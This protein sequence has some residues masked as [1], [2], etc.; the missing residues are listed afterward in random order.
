MC[1]PRKSERW[2]KYPSRIR[3]V[4]TQVASD[5]RN[6]NS[7]WLL[8]CKRTHMT[9]T[10]SI[11]SPLPAWP[12]S[13]SVSLGTHSSPSFSTHLA[14][15][16]VNAPHYTSPRLIIPPCIS[17]YF[18][19]PHHPLSSQHLSSPCLY[20]PCVASPQLT[21]PHRH[22][23]DGRLAYVTRINLTCTNTKERG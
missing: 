19:S 21:F 20:S 14:S 3:M 12:L 8:V 5:M 17:L 22:G 10:D 16:H 2:H 7:E 13:H 11:A 1:W 6:I 23:N 18:I 9:V 15:S 4:W